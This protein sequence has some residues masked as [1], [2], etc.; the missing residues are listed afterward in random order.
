[1]SQGLWGVEDND[2]DTLS[3]TFVFIINK[4][5]AVRISTSA[6]ISSVS[7]SCLLT[8]KVAGDRVGEQCK[9]LPELSTWE[10]ADRKSVV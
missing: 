9:S 3:L 4:V 1:M 5:R 10:S 6:C 2:Y 7:A 8:L